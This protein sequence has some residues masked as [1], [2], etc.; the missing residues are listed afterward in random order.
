MKNRYS[1]LTVNGMATISHIDALMNLN[2]KAIMYYEYNPHFDV[3][4]LP[5][6]V[7]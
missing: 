7:G 4:D 2:I 5:D 3:N 1:V 6:I